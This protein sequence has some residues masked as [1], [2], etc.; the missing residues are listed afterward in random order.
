M[1]PLPPFKPMRA[2]LITVLMA[3]II[4]LL[5]PGTPQGIPATPPSSALA[6]GVVSTAPQPP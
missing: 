3:L 6:G 1:S 4:I 5:V 2:L